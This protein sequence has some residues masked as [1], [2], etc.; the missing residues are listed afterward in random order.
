MPLAKLVLF[1]LVSCVLGAAADG[2]QVKTSS[3]S[4][5]GNY[6]PGANE[7]LGIPFAEPTQRFEPPGDFR[8]SY[9]ESPLKAKD[10]GP[11]CLQVGDSPDVTYGSEDCLAANVWQPAG[12]SPGSNLPVV[13]FIYGGSNQFG[14]A[15]PYNGSAMAV[16]QGVIYVSISYRTGPLGWMAFEEDSAHGLSTGNFGLLDTQSGLRWVQREIRHFGG[17]SSRVI[18]HGQSSGAMLVEL[19]LVMPGSR[20]LLSGLVSQSGGL[21]AS[22]LY[23]GV[24][25]SKSIGAS[26]GCPSGSLKLCLK[27]APAQKL[28]SQTYA[29]SWGPH[30]D[31]VTVPQDP[32]YLLQQGMIN[33]V[34]VI[35]GAQTNDTFRTLSQEFTGSDGRLQP[36]HAAA[37]EMRLAA[38]V[39]IKA[40]PRALK[41]YPVAHDDLVQNVH[42][43]GSAASD[44][45]L[46]GIRQRVSLVNKILP[47]RAYMYRFNW[48]Y[49]SNPNCSAEPNWHPPF[50]GAV[51]ED[52]VTFV[53][54][55][56]I[57]MFLGACCGRWG[58][59]LRRAPCQQSES[60]T[61][62]WNPDFGEGYHAY[63]NEKEW[64]FSEFVSGS[65]AKFADTGSPN[66]NQSGPW[67]RFLAGGDVTS[68][69]V[70]DADLADQHV[71]EATIHNNPAFCAFWD[72]LKME[73]SSQID[74]IDI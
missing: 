59:K 4:I 40:L 31:G 43:L 56:P 2:P 34:N 18:I 7:F 30:I 53:M 49:Q 61:S 11:A 27:R 1:I 67:P 26:L 42:S 68:N 22:S 5:E 60:C 65:W 50:L 54:G 28:T 71:V 17:D 12:T 36:L 48:F 16:R 25:A 44:R 46:C 38:M 33:P 72:A 39:G 52:E 19:H 20:S 74:E 41:L 47:G 23:S 3:G 10:Y 15:E 21:A 37:Y 6:L 9:A 63:F 55:Q 51:H 70:L 29:F 62:C 14:E 64:E 66:G 13:V 45:M 57:F 69:I 32:N 35:M 8:N 58:S 73:D 24:K